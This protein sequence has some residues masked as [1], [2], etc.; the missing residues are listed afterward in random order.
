MR[1]KEVVKRNLVMKTLKMSVFQFT[2]I[3]KILK[4][5]HSAN[6]GQYVEQLEHWTWGYTFL[7]QP[8][9]WQYLIL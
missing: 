5:T 8:L 9:F 2:R 3:D 4:K 6:A 1:P 7:Q